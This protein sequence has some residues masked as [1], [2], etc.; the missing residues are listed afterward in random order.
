MINAVAKYFK[1]RDLWGN[2]IDVL[3]G[4]DRLGIRALQEA[5]NL[6]LVT[7]LQAK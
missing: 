2:I 7:I 1:I 6:G 4:E 3:V 5:D